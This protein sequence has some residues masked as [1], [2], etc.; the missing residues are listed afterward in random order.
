MT[1]GNFRLPA[2]QAED[3]TVL[4]PAAGRVSESLLALP[5]ISAVQ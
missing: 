5:N 1:P 3:I 2:R 4:I